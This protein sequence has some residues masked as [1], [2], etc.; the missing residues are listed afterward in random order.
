MSHFCLV[1]R[2]YI[3]GDLPFAKAIGYLLALSGKSIGYAFP[4]GELL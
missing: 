4:R 3:T 2:L 1:C